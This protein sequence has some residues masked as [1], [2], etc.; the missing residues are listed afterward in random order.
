MI[1]K[2]ND[3]GKILAD[4]ILERFSANSAV[5]AIEE[6]ICQLA[7]KSIF[8]NYKDT[9]LLNDGLEYKLHSVGV[10]ISSW[11]N[12]LSLPNARIYLYYFCNSKLPKDKR[13]KVEQAKLALD[14]RKHLPYCNY[15]IPLWKTLSYTASCEELL[16]DKLNLL[17]E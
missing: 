2:Y 14:N 13:E 1:E 4:K 10:D 17:I 12:D 3:L 11:A 5:G 6:K 15:K 8:N 9:V 16:Q 7:K